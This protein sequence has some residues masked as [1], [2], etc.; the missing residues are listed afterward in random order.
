M[1][2]LEFRLLVCCA[3]V[4]IC[5]VAA[6]AQ[7]KSEPNGHGHGQHHEDQKH[8]KTAQPSNFRLSI[9]DVEVL[10]Q[11]GQR[12]KLYTDL[13][14]G[15]KVVINFIYTTCKA[16]CPLS[17]DNFA[18]LK[19]Q[20]GESL[21]KDVYLLSI[22]TDPENDTPAQLKSWS[23]RFEPKAGW[24]FVTGDAAAMNAVLHALTGEGARRGYHNPIAFVVDDEHGAWKRTNGLEAPGKL[25]EMLEGL[26][27]SAK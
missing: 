19:M 1:K 3:L 23:Q 26:S 17:G 27:A 21:G 22:T 6:K 20:L 8:D 10:N 13:I 15:R 5:A 16:V 18:R 9:P 25:V 11:D 4:S 24:T 14:K 7:I 2:K 12:L